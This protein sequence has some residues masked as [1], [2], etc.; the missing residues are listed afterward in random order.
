MQTSA[1]DSSRSEA[2]GRMKER[3]TSRLQCRVT[4][5][6]RWDPRLDAT[7][8][9][10]SVDE[11]IVTLTGKVPSY[12]Q[13]CCAQLLARRVRGVA[14]GNDGLE[15]RLTIGDHRSDAA[16]GR[17]AVDILESLPAMF[18]GRPHV[19]VHDGWV[20][21]DGIVD[22]NPLKHAAEE[23]FVH[24]AGIRGITNQIAVVPRSRSSEARRE[25]VAAVRRSAA[26]DVAD[27]S[28]KVSGATIVVRGTVGSCLEHDL[29]LEMA[30]RAP[31]IAR[32]ED[33]IVVRPHD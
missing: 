13:K 8:I 3:A 2:T 12:A 15:V 6:L 18:P 28:T 21:L 26:V 17:L 20:T 23:A 5:E 33:H 27:F 16:L 10:V 11:A 31:G 24:I 9:S 29:L 7:R 32:V 14:G 19:R 25:F 4:D 30:S 1:V 22:S